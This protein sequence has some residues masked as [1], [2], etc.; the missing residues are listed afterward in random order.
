MQL[1]LILA[2]AVGLRLTGK[3]FTKDSSRYT[4]SI[5][6]TEVLV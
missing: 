2:L 6:N 1:V 4:I 5:L 3:S